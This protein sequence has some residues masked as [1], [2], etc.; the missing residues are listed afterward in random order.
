MIIQSVL[1]KFE[2]VPKGCVLSYQKKQQVFDVNENLPPFDFLDK[3]ITF[4]YALPE[5]AHHVDI[6]LRVTMEQALMYEN[7]RQQNECQQWR[8]Y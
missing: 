6:S 1:T 7:S 3:T 8:D 5:R 2:N 4:C